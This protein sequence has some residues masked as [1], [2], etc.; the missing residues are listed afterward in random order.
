MRTITIDEASSNLPK[1]LN[2]LEAG[3]E[4]IISRDDKPVARLVRLAEVPPKRRRRVGETRGP[5]FHIPDEAFAP[6]TDE[7]LKEW[8][9]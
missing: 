1:V 5:K 8:G 6:L 2:E 4:V 7:E 9:L 3:S